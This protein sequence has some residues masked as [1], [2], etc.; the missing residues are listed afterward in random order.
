MIRRL[1]VA[2]LLAPALGGCASEEAKTVKEAFEQPVASAQVTIALTSTSAKGVATRITLAGPYKANGEGKLPTFDL[3]LD[4]TG[5]ARPWKARLI[6]GPDGVFVEYNGEIYAVPPEEVARLREGRRT[7][8]GGLL[9]RVEGWV[10]EAES[11]ADAEFAGEPVTRVNGT[12]DAAAAVKDLQALAKQ[13]GLSIVADL[14]RERMPDFSRPSGNPRFTVDVGRADGKLRRVEARVDGKDGTAVFS[15]RLAKVD[16]AVKV[17][18]PADG[19]PVAELEPQLLYDLD[20]GAGFPLAEPTAEADVALRE[21]VYAEQ[22]ELTRAVKRFGRRL[23]AVEAGKGPGVVV[24]PTLRL[25]DAVRAHADAIRTVQAGTPEYSRARDLLIYALE[26]YESTL[27]S[28]AAT[29][30]T[31]IDPEE[32]EGAA[33]AAARN[34]KRLAAVRDV[35]Y[36]GDPGPVIEA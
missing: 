36:P 19:V 22:L 7:E 15:V 20:L 17:D 14:T 12:L 30:E 8:L 33:D 1:L 23:D 16:E 9:A 26:A 13:P 32:I 31:A 6:S 4:V 18:V 35:F 5:F 29:A 24:P 2:M 10:D 3:Q 21:L 25:A 28:L 34:S 11:Q 27:R